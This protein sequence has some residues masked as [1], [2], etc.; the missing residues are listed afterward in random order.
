MSEVYLFYQSNNLKAV[1]D[2]NQIMKK[3]TFLYILDYYVE[4]KI[5]E[6]KKD[7]A[8]NMKQRLINFYHDRYLDCHNVIWSIVA[9]KTNE[10]NESIKNNGYI[11]NYTKLKIKGKNCKPK[12]LY[13]NLALLDLEIFYN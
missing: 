3:K 2:D 13:Q 5:Y 11:S 7:A 6:D 9:V 12:D 1:F 4:N 8:K 10:I